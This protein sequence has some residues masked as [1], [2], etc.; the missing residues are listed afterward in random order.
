MPKI[1]DHAAVVGASMGG[2]LAARVLA[3]SYRRVTIVERDP[4][5]DSGSARKGVP[6]AGTRTRCCRAGRRAGRTWNAGSAIGSG[7]CP[8]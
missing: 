2:L 7:P 1:G 8:T 3:D 6:Q 4:L 5:P